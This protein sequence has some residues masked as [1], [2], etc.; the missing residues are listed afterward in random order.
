[1]FV[2]TVLPEWL[3]AWID[4]YL[5]DDFSCI[6]VDG[7]IVTSKAEEKTSLIDMIT[8][9]VSAETTDSK[10]S[11]TGDTAIVTAV[12]RTAPKAP[13]PSGEQQE[14]TFPRMNVWARVN[15]DW[16]MLGCAGAPVR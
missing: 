7:T 11:I 10:V 14:T 13:S 12:T 5:S 3:G 15:G 9:G 16:K 1:M 8:D 6:L 4:K 2:Q